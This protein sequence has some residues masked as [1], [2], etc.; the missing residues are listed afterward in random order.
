MGKYLHRTTDFYSCTCYWLLN[1]LSFLDFDPF[2]TVGMGTVN[3]LMAA[4]LDFMLLM[5]Y[6]NSCPLNSTGS[7]RMCVRTPILWFS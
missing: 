4:T 1:M 6:T 5:I 3:S 2:W 7:L